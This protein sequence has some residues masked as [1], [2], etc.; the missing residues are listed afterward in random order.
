MPA[1][2]EQTNTK[3]PPLPWR[4]GCQCGQVRYEIRS[5]PLAF[6][7]CHCT[8]CQKQ[9]ASVHGLSLIVED[10]A[11]QFTGNMSQWQR[12]TDSGA[13]MHCRFCPQCGTRLYHQSGRS[14]DDRSLI[15]VNGGS[16]DHAARMKPV[17]H[18]WLK[19][20]QAGVVI[21]PDTLQYD[22]GP[23]DFDALA[24]A[25]RKYLESQGVVTPW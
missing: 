10:T 20:R 18:I 4:G 24:E 25:F 14:A 17:G 23:A 21:E 1:S 19:S 13:T 2:K 7:A 3:L 11:I 9:S 6:Y 5:A 15:S 16:L 12:H 22:S 8:E